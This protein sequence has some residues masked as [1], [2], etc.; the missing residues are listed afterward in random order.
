MSDCEICGCERDRHGPRD[1]GCPLTTVDGF[2]EKR[3]F[4]PGEEEE[5][6]K[7]K[8]KSPIIDI[9]GDTID[10]RE[11]RKVLPHKSHH[12]EFYYVI[13]KGLGYEDRDW[14]RAKQMPREQLVTLW[15]EAAK[16]E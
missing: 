7:Q 14:I 3:S 9:G 12:D 8:S 4:T 13:Y 11:I 2:S 6:T 15:R 16:D 1:L 5:K 10:L